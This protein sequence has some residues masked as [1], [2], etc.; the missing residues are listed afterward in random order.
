MGGCNCN[1]DERQEQITVSVTTQ[2][3]S[4]M[5]MSAI[6]PPVAEKIDLF[7]TIAMT[8]TMTPRRFFE[9]FEENAQALPKFYAEASKDCQD[10]IDFYHLSFTEIRAGETRSSRV[11]YLPDNR[12]LVVLEF[13]KD[14]A[15]PIATIFAASVAAIITYYFGR[16]QARIAQ[17]QR[18]IALDKLKHDLFNNRNEIYQ[19]AKKLLETIPFIDDLKHSN[20]TNV[21]AAYIKLDEG[22]FYFSP[23]ICAVLNDIHDL[24]ELFFTHLGE[25]ENVNIDDSELWRKSA[26][27]LAADQAAMRAI[28]ATLPQTFEPALAFTQLTTPTALT[29]TGKS[30]P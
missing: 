24:C 30:R 10:I 4:A 17:S 19:T 27:A 13:F 28:Y 9:L 3:T 11:F 5:A 15:S 26:E 16:A 22:R 12:G 2:A 21:R 8:Q 23:E 1:G 18:D 7:K 14:F 29:P 6:A 25:R 20:P